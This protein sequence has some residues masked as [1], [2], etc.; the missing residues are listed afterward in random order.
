MKAG[1]CSSFFENEVKVSVINLYHVRNFARS[2]KDSA[3]TDKIDGKMLSECGEKMNPKVQERKEEYR[4]ELEELTNRRDV[5]VE[6]AKEEKLRLKK[7]PV[8]IVV[9]SIQKTFRISE[10]ANSSH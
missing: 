5:L 8:K 10:R 3:K 2:A 6:S 7:E 9:E 1:H 4:F